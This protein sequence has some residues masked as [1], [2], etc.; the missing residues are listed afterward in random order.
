VVDSSHFSL[1]LSDDLLVD[2]NCAEDVDDSER[3]VVVDV[4][5]DAIEGKHEGEQQ[6]DCAEFDDKILL[7]LMMV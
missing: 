4:V 1:P 3:H 6:R 7:D 5:G 2:E